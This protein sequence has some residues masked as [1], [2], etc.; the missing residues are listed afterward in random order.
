MTDYKFTTTDLLNNFERILR[1]EEDIDNKVFSKFYDMRNYIVAFSNLKVLKKLKQ[2]L[3]ERIKS[4]K[5]TIKTTLNV[6]AITTA[7]PPKEEE[8]AEAKAAPAQAAPGATEEEKKAIEILK[9][10]ETE[11]KKLEHVASEIYQKDIPPQPAAEVAP[12]K[13]EKPTPMIEQKEMNAKKK[14]LLQI[15]DELIQTYD[16]YIIDKYIVFFITTLLNSEKINYNGF[17]R[18]GLI[19]ITKSLLELSQHVNITSQ[20]TKI[21]TFLDK[22]Y[23]KQE[24]QKIMNDLNFIQDLRHL[25]VVTTVKYVWQKTINLLKPLFDKFRTTETLRGGN[26]DSIPLDVI[27]NKI[28][29]KIKQIKPK[30]SSE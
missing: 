19:E 13:Q 6:P 15:Q 5:D 21:T 3:E 14:L 9:E 28:T 2:D 25:Q 26:S 11:I 12:E 29:E 20:K 10:V 18:S 24:L 8:K 16:I 27:K 4:E 17:D 23:N 7:T 30:E 22:P 1:H